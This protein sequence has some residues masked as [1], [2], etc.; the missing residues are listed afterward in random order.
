VRDIIR[1]YAVVIEQIPL[2]LILYD[3]VVSGPS[4]N[5]VKDNTLIGERTIR[6]IANSIAQHV[7]VTSRVGEVVLTVIL[8]HPAGLEEAVRITSLQ[9]LSILI[10]DDKRTWS[11]CKL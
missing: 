2:T 1:R 3:A 8:M 4:Y 10:Y 5:G 9:G 6:I 7:A 11:L